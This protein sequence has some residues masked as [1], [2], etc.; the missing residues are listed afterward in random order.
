[1][2][3]TGQFYSEKIYNKIGGSFLFGSA[4]GGNTIFVC[5]ALLVVHNT[6]FLLRTIFGFK[7]CA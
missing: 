7:K 3:L 5:Y 6:F 4:G 1:M 2:C